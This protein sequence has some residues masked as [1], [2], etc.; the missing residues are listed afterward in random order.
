MDQLK[1]ENGGIKKLKC[2]DCGKALA[3][4]WKTIPKA[5]FILKFKASCPFCGGESKEETIDGLCHYGPI[6][7]DESNYPTL[8]DN[9]ETNNSITGTLSSYF[10]IKKA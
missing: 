3:N 10:T 7:S 5:D 1:I 9:I 2:S 6:G 4:L 8:I